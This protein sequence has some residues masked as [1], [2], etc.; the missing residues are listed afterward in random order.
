MK[1]NEILGIGEMEYYR[2]Y[3][4]YMEEFAELLSLCSQDVV[5]ASEMF[6]KWFKED[7][8]LKAVVILKTTGS[9]ANAFA[10]SFLPPV[11]APTPKELMNLSH[12]VNECM[13]FV[14]MLSEQLKKRMK[15][16]R[17]DETY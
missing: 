6:E 11:K 12:D 4:K 9:F 1:I 14:C 13:Q 7:A 2:K 10:V 3:K 17:S 16:V 8:T 15:E 5:R